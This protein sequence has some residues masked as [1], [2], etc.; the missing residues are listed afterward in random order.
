MVGASADFCEPMVIRTESPELRLQI[1][2]LDLAS[3]ALS[4]PSDY[5]FH[6]TI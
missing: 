2:K 1:W 3:L 5:S 6:L 4:L